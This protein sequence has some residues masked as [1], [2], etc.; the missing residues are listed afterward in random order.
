[1]QRK[2]VL[3]LLIVVAL[4]T[5]PAAAFATSSSPT[6]QDS[7]SDMSAELTMT[8]ADQIIHQGDSVDFHLHITNQ[9]PDA[10]VYND[11]SYG[12]PIGEILL[13]PSLS[14]GNI[15]APD[16]VSCFTMPVGDVAGPVVAGAYGDYSLTLCSRSQTDPI[17]IGPGDSVDFTFSTTANA[18]VPDSTDILGV[19]ISF[20]DPDFIQLYTAMQNGQN[21]FDS[22]SD[23]N[24]LS[25]I[26]YSTT[27]ATTTT[28]VTTTTTPPEPTLVS[29]LKMEGTLTPNT[30][31]IHAGDSVALNYTITNNGPDAVTDPDGNSMFAEFFLPPDFSLDSVET[32]DGVT[33]NHDFIS[34]I[35]PGSIL[36]TNYPGYVFVMCITPATPGFTI[37]D[38]GTVDFTIHGTASADFVD[39]STTFFGVVPIGQDPDLDELSTAFMSGQDPLLV[40]VNNIARVTY[41]VDTPPSSQATNPVPT[42]PASVLGEQET[43]GNGSLSGILATTGAQTLTLIAIAAV[44]LAGGISMIAASRKKQAQPLGKQRQI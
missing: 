4:L 25:T 3:N 44:L 38:G 5:F 14:V 34:N 6:T 18:D 43:K 39:G 17:T 42:V 21:P 23:K 7:G 32:P 22:L 33:C 12:L 35:L 16:G 15:V 24:L 13:P 20:Q 19:A 36:D 40:D 30:V 41:S 26:H 37:A 10:S 9:G 27:P 11:E 28:E 2:L 1:M 8:P 31:E 29:D